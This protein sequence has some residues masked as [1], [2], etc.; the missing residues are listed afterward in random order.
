MTIER[1]T[2]PDLAPPLGYAHA[3]VASGMRP[4]TTAG[5]APL[6]AEGG[7]VE[8]GDVRRQA[9]QTIGN[10]LRQ[11]AAAGASGEDVMKTTVHVASSDRTDLLAA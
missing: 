6:D 5:A 10:L 2:V 11:L 3:A 9:R 8:V 7:L 1:L 4:V